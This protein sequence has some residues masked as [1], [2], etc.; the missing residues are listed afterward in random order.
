MALQ[1]VDRAMQ[2]HGAEGICQDTPLAKFWAGLRTLRY[3]DGPD[4][5]C[6]RVYRISEPC[7]NIIPGSYATNWPA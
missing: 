7:L 6:L 4:E 5:V 3:A 1:V 2:V